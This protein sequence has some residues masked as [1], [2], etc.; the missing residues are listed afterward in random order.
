MEATS[1]LIINFF[2]SLTLCEYY[3]YKILK[4]VFSNN[5]SEGDLVELDAL[6]RRLEFLSK[7]RAEKLLSTLN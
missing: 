3:E 4:G 2:T 5:N 7:K 6:V 1:E